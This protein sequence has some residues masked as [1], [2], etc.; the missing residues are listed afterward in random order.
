MAKLES[1]PTACPW[2]RGAKM[3]PQMDA[4]D[5]PCPVCKGGGV[6]DKPV[7]LGTAGDAA[8]I[9]CAEAYQAVGF[10]AHVLGY[11]DMAADDP[12]QHQLTKLL[13]NLVAAANE[14]PIPHADL[15]PF[16]WEVSAA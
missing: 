10:L 6:S 12:R 9:V 13:D 5:V 15:L 16:G 8:L 4:D 1:Q 11:W 14:E 2:C 3:V 7:S